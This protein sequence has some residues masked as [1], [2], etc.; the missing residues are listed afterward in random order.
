MLIGFKDGFKLIGVS[1][2]VFCAVFVCTFMLSFYIDVQQLEGVIN[3]PQSRGL[4]EAQLSTAKITSV[5]SGGVL[6]LIAVVMLIFYIKLFVDGH[7]KQLGVI[8]AMGYSNGKIALKFH[9]FGFSVLLGCLIGFVGGY[10]AMPWIYKSMAIDGLPDIAINFHYELLLGL[11]IAPYAVFSA[12]ACLYAYF[13]L[14]SSVGELLRGKP[15]KFKI[16]A[17]GREKD[18]PFIIEMLF[19][20]LG[21]KKSLAFFVAFSTFC[22][23]A[24]VQMGW[25]MWDLSAESMGYIIIT[26]GLVL[27]AVTMFMAVT[28]LINANGKNI[29]VMKAFGYSV[30]DCALSVL[31]GYAPFALLGFCVGTAYQFGLLQI[32]VNLVFAD[33]EEVP[34]YEFNVP[35]F[36]ITFALFIVVYSAVTAFYV[37]RLNKASVKEIMLEN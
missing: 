4:Y 37:F 35:V 5:I 22:F 3:D 19:K 11:V 15:D 36:F 10:A 31:G 21:S 25:S 13:A 16:K 32:M 7:A 14:R 6:M 30:K 24:M 26:I 1:V 33:V 12:F 18:R 34:E 27:A 29:A 23:G 8:K 2:V 17:G 28:T 20:T 9:V